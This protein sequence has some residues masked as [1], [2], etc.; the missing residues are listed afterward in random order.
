MK[1]EV[2]VITPRKGALKKQAWEAVEA[3]LM[4]HLENRFE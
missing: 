1:I 3:Q 4:E 2:K